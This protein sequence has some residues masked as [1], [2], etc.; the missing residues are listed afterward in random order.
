MWQELQLLADQSSGSEGGS[1][2]DR[3][4]SGTLL[5]AVTSAHHAALEG[6]E[7]QATWLHLRWR[8][9]QV[10]EGTN[11][12]VAWLGSSICVEDLGMESTSPG[13]PSVPLLKKCLDSATRAE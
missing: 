7:F 2:L 5:F 1:A 6:G 11:E 13:A 8:G 12:D 3:G 9:S 10:P 4:F